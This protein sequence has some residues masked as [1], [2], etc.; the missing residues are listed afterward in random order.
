[1]IFVF[2]HYSWFTLFF[3]FSF[4]VCLFVCLFLSFLGL[5]L[6]HVAFARLGSNQS[7]SHL[8]TPEPQQ[9]GI[10]ATSAIYTTTHSNA[11]SLTHWARSG[12]EP[13]S[14]WILVQI[15]FHWAMT[16]TPCFH[17]LSTKFLLNKDTEVS[18]RLWA[19]GPAP[20]LPCPPRGILAK[21]QRG[22]V[23][24]PKSYSYVVRQQEKPWNSQ[25]PIPHILDS[26][27]C[28]SWKKFPALIYFSWL[29]DR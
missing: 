1:M 15:H 7:C 10:W 9:L 21:A 2:F 18:L 23:S 8:P 12:I 13:A 22:E 14:S 11:R 16:G 5:H 3:Q 29:W 26:K 27:K 24:C 25:S 28:I 4:F 19:A 20:C 17:S 6:W